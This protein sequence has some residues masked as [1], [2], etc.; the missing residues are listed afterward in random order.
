[1]MDIQSTNFKNIK[2]ISNNTWCYKPINNEL[3]N[4]VK[5]DLDIEKI[6][7]SILANRG[8]EGPDLAVFLDHT[9]KNN[10]P[11]PALINDMEKAIKRISHAVLNKEPIGI[12]GD[13]DVDGLVSA[14][15]LFKYLQPYCPV[16][17]KIPDRFNDGYGPN[18]RFLEEFEQ[19]NINLIITVDCGSNS[20]DL[21]SKKN[22]LD[23]IIFDHH[24]TD[25]LD[26]GFANVNPNRD[27][28]KS[29]LNYLAAAG[30]VFLAII[31]LNRELRNRDF[32]KNSSS[33]WDL[34]QFVPLVAMATI[35][36]VVP[37]RKLN[38]ALVKQGLILYA[39]YNNYG[40]NS[41]LGQKSSISDI[42]YQDIGYLIGPMI[43]AGGRMG[44]SYLGFELL[45]SDTASIADQITDE[46]K[47]LNE[48]RKSKE[49]YC[50][51]LAIQEYENNLKKDS[52]I[53]L[54]LDALHIG[55]IGLISSRL[56]NRY[57][58]TSCVMTSLPDDRD[59]LIGSARSWGDVNIGSL[60]NNALSNNILITGGG[61]KMAAGFKL[62]RKNL[63][64]FRDFLAETRLDMGRIEGKIIKADG[65]LMASAVTN[66]LVKK[67]VDLG[68]YGNSFE[69]PLFIFPG[70]RI[71]EL[72]AL[73]N[74]HLKLKI[75]DSSGYKVNAISFRS[76]DLPLGQFLRENQ[77]KKIHFLGRLTMNNWNNKSTP[78]FIIDDAAIIQ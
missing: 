35:A 42:S 57:Q 67:I 63:R 9:L 77:N 74:E 54:E 59:I 39:R 73:K 44:R 26:I 75:V 2:S 38:R 62:H 32:F 7:A 20:V 52:I 30:V 15:I 53:A 46:L 24:Q 5:K 70:H 48:A 31:S 4:Q 3:K 72:T 45:T 76:F 25:Q 61:H 1:M 68:P 41:I 66:E 10:M 16:T 18:L 64:L 29:G 37:L 23:I 43:N 71:S 8:I 60:I 55:V 14:S 69:E 12:I 6:T 78:Q 36:D 65:L 51:E 13:Y 27:D 22:D 47:A 28:D 19:S 56:T 11:D 21:I 40:I 34:L 17:V 58:K 50:L 33:D 49:Q